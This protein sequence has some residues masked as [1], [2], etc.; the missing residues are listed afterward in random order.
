MSAIFCPFLSTFFDIA[1]FARSSS[2]IFNV[3]RSVSLSDFGGLKQNKF[4]FVKHE[5]SLAY[6]YSNISVKLLV[7]G[8]LPRP[9]MHEPDDS[10]DDAG[11]CDGEI[12]GALDVPGVPLIQLLVVFGGDDVAILGG[13][14]LC[15]VG[16]VQTLDRGVTVFLFLYVLLHA[17]S[18]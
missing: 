1:F 13:C 11:S 15:G 18:D 9:R 14:D 7:A 5:I 4:K 17:R 16:V 10:P 2:L 12:D 6:L 8:V 3:A